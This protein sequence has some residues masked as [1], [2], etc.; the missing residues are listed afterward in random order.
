MLTE[1]L[2]LRNYRALLAAG[3][4]RAIALDQSRTYSRDVCDWCGR[5]WGSCVLNPCDS[6]GNIPPSS[7]DT[8]QA[9]G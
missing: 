2:D 1:I 7:T 4:K 8:E 5:A 6:A 9:N 3:T